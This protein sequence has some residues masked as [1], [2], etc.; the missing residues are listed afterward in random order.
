M[1]IIRRE[2]IAAQIVAIIQADFSR[3][4]ADERKVLMGEGG[5][6]ASLNAAVD[7]ATG[8]SVWFALVVPR[9]TQNRPAGPFPGCTQS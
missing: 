3:A 6:A 7:G 4:S 5:G 2:Q 8:W 9:K 1:D